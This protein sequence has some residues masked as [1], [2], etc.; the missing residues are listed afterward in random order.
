MH[1]QWWPALAITILALLGC[2]GGKSKSKSPSWSSGTSIDSRALWAASLS[3]PILAADPSGNMLILDLHSDNGNPVL[4]YRYFSATNH[5]WSPLQ[6]VPGA[7]SYPVFPA[8]AM[9]DDGHGIACWMDRSGTS[10]QVQSAVYSP[11]A[12]WSS[13]QTIGADARNFQLACRGNEARLL[14]QPISARTPATDLLT[15]RYT[16]SSGWSLQEPVPTGISASN[17]QLA[18]DAGGDAVAIWQSDIPSTSAIGIFASTFQPGSGWEV[19]RQLNGASTPGLAGQMP[20]VAMG[21]TGKVMVAWNQYQTPY[22]PAVSK[23][24]YF[25]TYTPGSGWSAAAL[26]TLNRI[27]TLTMNAQG[28]ALATGPTPDPFLANT[29]FHLQSAFF[30]GSSWRDLPAF[31]TNPIRFDAFAR[32][33]TVAADSQG[34]FLVAF[35]AQQDNSG[36]CDPWFATFSA[37]GQRT[38]STPARLPGWSAFGVNYLQILGLPQ[39]GAAVTWLI[40]TSN[41]PTDQLGMYV[42]SY[43]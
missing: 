2:G 7:S 6:P 26:A 5:T 3:A 34:N 29:L 14:W 33:T 28:M 27:D 35:L 4:S 13:P 12:G 23:G 21:P 16:T 39:G 18:V 20:R 17:F 37:S 22:Y 24:A 32:Y 38:W 1:K 41:L 42:S 15:A 31:A 19:A 40:E 36:S 25:A 11:S 43:H 30:D 8:V 9:T 10:S